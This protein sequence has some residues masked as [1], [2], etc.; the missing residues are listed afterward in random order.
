[1]YRSITPI[2]LLLVIPLLLLQACLP[3]K[4]TT[5]TIRF[6]REGNVIRVNDPPL[7]VLIKPEIDHID[8]QEM[9]NII[10]LKEK[11]TSPVFIEFFENKSATTSYYYD[12]KYI[13]RNHDLFYLGP[14]SING[15]EWARVVNA[16]SDGYLLYGYITLKKN[17]FV[18][19]YQIEGLSEKGYHTYLRAQNTQ[20]LGNKERKYLQ[21]RF[22][23]FH[24]CVDIR[25]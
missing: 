14:A 3:S 15:H 18:F 11:N 7:A 12:L 8:Q 4:Q 1:M 13:A 17:H 16:D 20:R 5:S 2:A 10:F 24:R 23:D 19:I 22:N 25:S 21:T 6:L 9:K